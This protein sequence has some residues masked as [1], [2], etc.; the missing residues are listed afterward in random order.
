MAKSFFYV[1]KNDE[2]R[3]MSERKTFI[4]YCK[5]TDD[6]QMNPFFLIIIAIYYCYYY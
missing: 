4:L 2:V 6:L 3:S 5:Q 1:K